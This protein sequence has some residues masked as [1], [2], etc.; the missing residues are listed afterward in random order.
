MRAVMLPRRFPRG[1]MLRLGAALMI[2]WFV[3]WT[4]TYVLR[5]NRSESAPMPDAMPP[6]SAQIALV[7]ALAIVGP[8]VISGFRSAVGKRPSGL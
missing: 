5:S 8:W 4:F 3:F 7:F 1:A 6:L 2:L